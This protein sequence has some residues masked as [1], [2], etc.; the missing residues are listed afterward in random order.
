MATGAHFF[1]CIAQAP[2]Q[3]PKEKKSDV[4]GIAMFSR[5][6]DAQASP[7]PP[8]MHFLASGYF[9]ALKQICT[10]D[11]P[12]AKKNTPAGGTE[13][14]TISRAFVGNWASFNFTGL[15][16]MDADKPTGRLVIRKKQ[17]YCP[18]LEF[19]N[20]YAHQQ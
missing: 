7:P 19:L 16:A 17:T 6:A 20:S 11:H 2:P 1:T 5:G 9:F 10:L 14:E 4:G 8:R 12:P 18:V 13:E 15:I 3:Y